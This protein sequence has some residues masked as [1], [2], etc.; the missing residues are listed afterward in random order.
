MAKK[1]YLTAGEDPVTG[2]LGV[3]FDGVNVSD[4]LLSFT[5]SGILIAHDLVEHVNGMSSIGSISDEL[6]A[7]GGVWFVRGQNYAISQYHPPHHDVAS[8]ICRMASE[9]GFMGFHP[10]SKPMRLTGH[11]MECDMDDIMQE[12]RRMIRAEDIEIDAEISSYLDAAPGLIALGYSKAV[13]R[14]SRYGGS[15]GALCMFSQIRDA[16]RDNFSPEFEGMR[17][18]LTVDFASKDARLD[19]IWEDY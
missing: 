12:A 4:E 1:Y 19:E 16:F 2:E 14:W 7:C 13:K 8:D 3:R 9:I 17:Y 5:T 11:P 10:E 6:E 15:A 18:C